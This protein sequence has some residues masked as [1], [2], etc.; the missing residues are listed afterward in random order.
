MRAFVIAWH[1]LTAVPLSGRVHDPE[2]R[3]L[4]ASMAWYPVVGLALG[5]IVAGVD[6]VLTLWLS[7]AVVGVLLLLLLVGLTRG[8]HQDGLADTV[9]GL[10]GGRTPAAR[11]AIMRD[12]RIGAVGATALCLILLVRAVGLDEFVPPDRQALLLCLPLVG[13]WMMVATAYGSTYARAEE[14]LASP[15]LAHLTGRHVLSA[16]LWAALPL[17]WFLGIVGG[18]T[19]L[20]GGAGLAWAIRRFC[21]RQFGGLTGDMLGATNEV[22]EALFVLAGPVLVA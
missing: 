21:R 11:L 17:Y 4:A 16:T 22:A 1:F 7:Q 5:G 6:W 15:F 3:E 18:T 13:R 2:P 20:L 19:V 14:G 8:L 12:G 9:D 10:A